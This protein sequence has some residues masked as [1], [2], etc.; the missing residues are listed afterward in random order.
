MAKEKLGRGLDALLADVSPSEITS[1]SDRGGY[2]IELSKIKP[3]P[4][5]PRQT[6]DEKTL[7]HLTESIKREGII[8]PLLVTQMSNDTYQIVSGERRWRAA[9]KA[10]MEKVPVVV[11]NVSPQQSVILG[12]VEN[13]QREDL[14]AF[15]EAVA[16]QRLQEEHGL[17]QDEIGHAIGKSRTAV[18]N[19]IRL[20]NL[21]EPV[22]QMLKGGH[23]GEANARTLL[24]LPQSRQESVARK[25][26]RGGLSVRQTE[27]LV[28]REEKEGGQRPR[29]PDVVQL[30]QEL[31][32]QLG[33]L[34]SITRRSKR[35]GG[36]L[37]I[38]YRN[39]EQLQRFIDLLRAE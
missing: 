34:V 18:S 37:K 16:I 32:D 3:N 14:N 30:E 9:H 28:K 24:S 33:A 17:T 4:H 38:Q 29:D 12:L 21:V 35:G 25:V 15:E 22:Q 19:S 23:I 7:D 27:A 13:L 11:R 6:F 39:L 26:I 36:N 8:Q 2:E 31:S 10:G 20:L 1:E 5:Q